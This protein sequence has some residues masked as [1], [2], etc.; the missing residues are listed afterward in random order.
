M[1]SV[2][3]VFLVILVVILVVVGIAL[4]R[5]HLKRYEAATQS[6]I[7]LLLAPAKEVVF[8]SA[9]FVCLLAGLYAKTT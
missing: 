5:R 2:L 9:L 3:I 7:H 1:T 6:I 8:S 4:S